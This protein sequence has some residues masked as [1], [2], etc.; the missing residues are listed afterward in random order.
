MIDKHFIQND[1]LIGIEYPDYPVMYMDTDVV[2]LCFTCAN[3]KDISSIE[4]FMLVYPNEQEIC[5]SCGK[6]IIH[7]SCYASGK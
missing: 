7:K 1:K 6:A 5:E 3:T 4:T 2:I